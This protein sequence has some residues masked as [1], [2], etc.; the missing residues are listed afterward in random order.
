M[1]SEFVNFDDLRLHFLIILNRTI[2]WD[3]Q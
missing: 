2:S 3:D 1:T